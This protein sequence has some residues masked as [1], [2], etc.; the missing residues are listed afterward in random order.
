[1]STHSQT[2]EFTTGTPTWFPCWNTFPCASAFCWERR[3]RCSY[4]IPAAARRF[5]PRRGCCWPWCWPGVAS[6]RSGVRPRPPFSDSASI[7]IDDATLKICIKYFKTF[8]F[9][10]CSDQV[11]LV[12]WLGFETKLLHASWGGSYKE[13][14]KRCLLRTGRNPGAGRLWLGCINRDNAW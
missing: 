9:W 3:R 12:S 14:K 13:N 1:M 6:N 8:V 10:Q 5:D 2:N 11:W 4:P 7:F